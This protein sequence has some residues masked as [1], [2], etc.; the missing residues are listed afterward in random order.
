MNKFT[1]RPNKSVKDMIE[2]NRNKCKKLEVIMKND[3]DKYQGKFSG[4]YVKSDES[5]NDASQWIL[6]K[7]KIWFDDKMKLWTIGI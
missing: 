3:A 5:V 6:G 7:N 2:V 4:I 1:V